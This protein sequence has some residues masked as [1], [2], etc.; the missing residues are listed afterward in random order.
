[1]LMVA[2]AGGGWIHNAFI[3]TQTGTIKK[4]RPAAGCAPMAGEH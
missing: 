3:L 2:M 1:M 4:R